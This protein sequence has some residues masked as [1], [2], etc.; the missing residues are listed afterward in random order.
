MPLSS[1]RGTP[2][3]AYRCDAYSAAA[4]AGGHVAAEPE[5]TVSWGT[6]GHRVS[7]QGW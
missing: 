3:L 4:A 7:G 6:V 1:A 2:L 5:G